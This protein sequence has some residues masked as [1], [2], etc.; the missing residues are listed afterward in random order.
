MTNLSRQL[1]IFWQ[2]PDMTRVKEISKDLEGR[3][4]EGNNIIWEP[5]N[6]SDPKEDISDYG[7][8]LV[9]KKEISLF[10]NSLSELLKCNFDIGGPGSGSVQLSYDLEETKEP[11]DLR[12]KHIAYTKT[13]AE[14]RHHQVVDS[15]TAEMFKGYLQQVSQEGGAS[16]H[17]RD[18]FVERLHKDYSVDIGD[19]ADMFHIGKRVVK[20]I[21]KYG[22]STKGRGTAEV[23]PRFEELEMR[24]NVK[25]LISKEI[26]S[27][28]RLITVPYLQG[29][30]KQQLGQTI[31]Q[32]HLYKILKK[33][34]GVKWRKVRY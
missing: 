29:V 12:N 3:D 14:N 24:H 17:I 25:E 2:Q 5:E 15:E 10:Q 23:Q 7:S 18:A 27:K 19:L 11:H 8:N 30:V 33:D 9:R 28:Q 34:M 22:S 20:K 1:K 32:H 13:K 26:S 16:L 6:D 4:P 21:V 31:S